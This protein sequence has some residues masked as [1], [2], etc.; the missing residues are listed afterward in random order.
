MPQYDGE[1]DVV[2]K[3]FEGDSGL[4]LVVR[5]ICLTP[6]SVEDD[7]LRTNIFQLTYTIGGQV[8]KFVVNTKSCKMYYLR[9]S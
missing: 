4:L 2:E 6:R 3:Y 1:E 5:R 8:Y 9:K 7:W